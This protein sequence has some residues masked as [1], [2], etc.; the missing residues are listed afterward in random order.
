MKDFT[1]LHQSLY[2][3]ALYKSH[4]TCLL[5]YNLIRSVSEI[6]SWTAVSV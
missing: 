2:D 5:K 3:N 6:N 1:G 4:F